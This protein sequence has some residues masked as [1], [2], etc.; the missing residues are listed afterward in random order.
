MRASEGEGREPQKANDERLQ[1][2]VINA[3]ER[4]FGADFCARVKRSEP[5][6]KKVLTEYLDERD[7][8]VRL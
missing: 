6:W 3:S 8:P 2:Q 1:P 7:V 5:E 4:L